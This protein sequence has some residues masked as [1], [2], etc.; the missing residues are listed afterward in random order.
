MK[1][2]IWKDIPNYKGFYKVSN[3]GRV[4]SLDRYVN[5]KGNAKRRVKGHIFK[6]IDRGNGYL[7]VCLR[8]N[9]K[10]KMFNVHVL[11]AM[12]F[13]NWIEG[14]K[15]GLVCDHLDNNRTNNRADNLKMVTNRYN[16]TK[17]KKG[18]SKYTGV[19]WH[20]RIRKWSA[21]IEIKGERFNL[22]YF[23]KELE[24]SK[25]YQKEL[26]KVLSLEKD[27]NTCLHKSVE[28]RN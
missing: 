19:S 17:D 13:C 23:D 28:F 14:R 16:I 5:T 15:Q 8:K 18:T 27:K 7:C 22:G 12:A 4:K 10:K 6:L 24:A 1:K 11:V 2:E 25:V 3:L 9:G 20:K 26:K 21:R